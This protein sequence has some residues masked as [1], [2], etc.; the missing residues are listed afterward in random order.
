MMVNLPCL[1]ASGANFLRPTYSYTE[2]WLS[3]QTGSCPK[4]RT[5]V[6]YSSCLYIWFYWPNASQGSDFSGRTP[7]FDL[8]VL[9]LMK[10]FCYFIHFGF[11]FQNPARIQYYWSP[12]EFWN[13]C[14]FVSMLPVLL[15]FF[16]WYLSKVFSDHMSHLCSISHKSLAVSYRQSLSMIAFSLVDYQVWLCNKYVVP[17]IHPHVPPRI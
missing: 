6:S 16:A 11:L 4:E 14:L 3:F 15:V 7:C 12:A 10:F 9:L 5:T 8:L 2:C 1:M 17:W 13:S